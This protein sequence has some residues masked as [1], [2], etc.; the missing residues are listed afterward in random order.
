M[1]Y[2]QFQHQQHYQQRM[3]MQPSQQY[4]LRQRR[5]SSGTVA[6]HSHPTAKVKSN[7][8]H[9]QGRPPSVDRRSRTPS[10]S[11]PPSISS[12]ASP[13]PSLESARRSSTNSLSSSASQTTIRSD[14]STATKVSISKRLRRVFSINHGKKETGTGDSETSSIRSVGSK[15]RRRRSSFVSISNLFHKNSSSDLSQ[16]TINEEEDDVHQSTSEILKQPSRKNLKARPSCK[17]SDACKPT[18]FSKQ[19]LRFSSAESLPSPAASVVSS[20]YSQTKRCTTEE[21]FGGSHH[22]SPILKPSATS[23][24]SSL[25]KCR[26]LQF[27]PTIRVHETFSPSEYDRRCDSNA[28][29]QKL[30]PVLAMKIKQE[31]NEYKLSDME[32]HIDSRQYT[33]FFL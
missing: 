6:S 15:Q 4:H 31:L 2:L 26:K 12:S 13:V 7:P 9:T 28:T 18:S 27:C 23:S 10:I 33:H 20:T 17:V 3:F 14:I 32:I 24:T 5:A 21:Y 25:G 8:H 16:S 22:R 29:C 1:Q 30:T 11:R 19:S